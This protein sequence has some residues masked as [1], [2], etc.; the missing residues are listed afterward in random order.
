MIVFS[1][2][3]SSLSVNLGILGFE[4]IVPEVVASLLTSLKW[5]SYDLLLLLDSFRDLWYNSTK[6]LGGSTLSSKVVWTTTFMACKYLA[7][8][9]TFGF[10]LLVFVIAF[11]LLEFTGFLLMV[12]RPIT[13][14]N[15]LHIIVNLWQG[16]R[17][18]RTLVIIS[19]SKLIMLFCLEEIMNKI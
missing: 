13:S 17:T 6:C 5:A 12:V 10:V 16:S 19:Q 8:P 11:A 14:F 1:M 15:I 4:G 9:L 3:M 2:S 7:F 18:N